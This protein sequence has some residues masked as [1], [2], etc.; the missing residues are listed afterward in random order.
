MKFSRTSLAGLWLIDLGTARRRAR[1]SRANLLRK[2]ILRP[3]PQH[4]LA[5]MQSHPHQKTR[6]DPRHAFPGRAR[7]PE[8]KLI[9]CAA[10]AIFD[11]AVDVRPDS[12]TFGKWEG[13][14]LTAAESPHAL[15]PRRISPTAFNAWPT[16]AKSS[17][18]CPNFMCPSW[19]AASVGTIRPSRSNGHCRTQLS[20]SATKTSRCSTTQC[21]R[22]PESERLSRSAQKNGLCSFSSAT[23]VNGPCPGQISVSAGNEKICSRTFCRRIP[24]IDFR[25]RSSRQRSRLRRWRRAAHP[26]ARCRSHKLCH[27][28]HARACRDW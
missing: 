13:F 26:P 19:R 18:R 20:P 4:P 22:R 12:P 17:T 1:F 8:I 15:R 14:E 6:H 21:D 24:R 28:R 11:V 10:G 7:R 25:Y 5:A 16:T 23:V 3:R 2:R 27:L 9:R